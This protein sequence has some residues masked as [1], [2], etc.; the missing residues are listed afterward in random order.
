MKTKVILPCTKEQIHSLYAMNYRVMTSIPTVRQ[1]SYTIRKK[2]ILTKLI[3]TDVC[4]NPAGLTI[5]SSQELFS[6]L[7]FF[8]RQTKT[9]S[10]H[11]TDFNRMRMLCVG[12]LNYY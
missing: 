3:T 12:F 6:F 1:G 10:N 8:V 2:K 9:G 5:S 4:E 7:C 11:Y